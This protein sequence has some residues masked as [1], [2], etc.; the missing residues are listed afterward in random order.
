[1]CINVCIYIYIYLVRTYT[2]TGLNIENDPNK[3][4][5]LVLLQREILALEEVIQGGGLDC[6]SISRVDQYARQITLEINK[7]EKGL[8]DFKGRDSIAY[9]IDQTVNTCIY[10]CVYTYVY[11]I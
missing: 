5:F 3:I 11:V 9:T 1:M 8:K 7:N 4:E 2:S 6:L 10:M